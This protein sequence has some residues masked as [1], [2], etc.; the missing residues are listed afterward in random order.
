[1]ASEKRN[2]WMLLIGIIILILVIPGFFLKFL[3]FM[4]VML[5]IGLIVLGV[6]LILGWLLKK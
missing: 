5:K 4:G 1:M 6:L 2:K 3:A